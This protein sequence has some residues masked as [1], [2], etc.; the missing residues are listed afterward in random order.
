[1]LHTN[2]NEKCDYEI[3][4][5]FCNFNIAKNILSRLNIVNFDN[6]SGQ[7]PSINFYSDILYNSVV[8]SNR[9]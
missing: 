7:S 6:R 9:F 2:L 4:A 1:M 5:L 8:L 3:Y